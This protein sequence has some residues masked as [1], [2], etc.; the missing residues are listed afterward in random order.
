VILGVDNIRIG[1]SDLACSV[2]FYLFP[3]KKLQRE[4][5]NRQGLT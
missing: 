3:L 5:A 4:P 1:I 2:D